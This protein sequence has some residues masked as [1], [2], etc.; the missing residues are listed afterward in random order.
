[1]IK[2]S[3]CELSDSNINDLLT[4]NISLTLKKKPTNLNG[5]TVYVEET[6]IRDKV[7]L[8]LNYISAKCKCEGQA[9]SLENGN[10]EKRCN[11]IIC[12]EGWG[13]ENCSVNCEHASISDCRIDENARICSG[14]GNCKCSQCE[15]FYSYAGKYCENRCPINRANRRICS[16][17]GICTSDGCKCDKNFNGTDCSCDLRTTNCLANGKI[18][19]GHGKCECNRCNCDWNYGGHFCERISNRFCTFYKNVA[20]NKDIWQNKTQYQGVYIHNNLENKDGPQNVNE[21]NKRMCETIDNEG[22]SV[23]FCGELENEQIKLFIMK[24]SCYYSAQTKIGFGIFLAFGFTI[25]IGVM[26]ILL[27]KY[28]RDKREYEKFALETSN[29]FSTSE[30]GRAH[31]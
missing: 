4:F 9:K 7:E 19:S 30:I 3:T 5:A 25:L 14:N 17:N 21:C 12:N 6:S 13:G 10:G 31:V 23:E 22:C 20:E 24:R 27:Q 16:G 18:C 26:I 29:A 15:C 28:L 11:E 1:M 8:N 2:G